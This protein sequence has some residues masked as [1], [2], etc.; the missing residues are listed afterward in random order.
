VGSRAGLDDVEKRKFLTLLGL[1]LRHSVGQAVASRY[2]D[3]ALPAT[4][5]L[6]TL[7]SS[8]DKERS[9]DRSDVTDSE[10]L[11][12]RP[13]VWAAGTSDRPNYF[14]SLFLQGT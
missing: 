8:R 10:E 5:V 12:S 9:E 2:T 3:Y 11:M 1:E 4:S 13:L 14:I 6:R 7:L